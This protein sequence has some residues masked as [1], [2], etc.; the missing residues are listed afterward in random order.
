M[1]SA[2][3]KN[4]MSLDNKSTLDNA[5]DSVSNTANKIGHDAREMYNNASD[6]LSHASACVKKEIRDNPLRSS[7]IAMGVGIVLGMLFRR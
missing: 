2:T 1:F 6:E 7:A 3:P 5:K 4:D